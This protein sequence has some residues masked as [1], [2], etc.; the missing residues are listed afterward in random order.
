MNPLIAV[1]SCYRNFATFKGRAQ[2]S[3]YWFFQI[4]TVLLFF[5]LIGLDVS[6]NRHSRL[7][8]DATVIKIVFLIML[9]NFLPLLA[10]QVRRLHDMELPGWYAFVGMLPGGG[11]LLLLI[12]SILP[13]TKGDNKFGPDPRNA[14]ITRPKGA[15][16]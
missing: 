14:R 9:L 1:V 2:R 4:W 16:A 12:L 13:G 15:T 5:G 6:L 8:H 10:V 7:L 3:E 11:A